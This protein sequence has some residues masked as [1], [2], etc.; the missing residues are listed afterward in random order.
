[1]IYIFADVTFRRLILYEPGQVSWYS[2]LATWW[3]T[4]RPQ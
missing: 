1:M 3:T 4:D 2:D